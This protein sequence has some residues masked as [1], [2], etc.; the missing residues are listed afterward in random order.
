MS[1]GPASSASSPVAQKQR[2]GKVLW[3][4]EVKLGKTCSGF[5][6]GTKK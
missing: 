4:K 1:L 2:E 5:E 3:R 6:R